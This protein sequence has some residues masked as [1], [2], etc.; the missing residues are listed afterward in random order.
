MNL[1]KNTTVSAMEIVALPMSKCRNS[2]MRHLTM[3]Q[4]CQAADAAG[5]EMD[6]ALLRPQPSSSTWSTQK[7][8][9]VPPALLNS[10]KSMSPAVAPPQPSNLGANA[11]TCTAQ[12]RRLPL[13]AW[14]GI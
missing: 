6:R 2:V 10:I 4:S 1:C 7:S 5:I 14:A 11:V 9:A 12:T 8:C 3:L 13:I